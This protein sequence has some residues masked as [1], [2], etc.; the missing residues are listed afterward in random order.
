[1]S[2][3]GR[4]APSRP[5]T[6]NTPATLDAGLDAC[7]ERGFDAVGRLGDAGAGFITRGEGGLASRGGN[8]RPPIIRERLGRTELGGRGVDGGLPELD[9]V[10]GCASAQQD[11]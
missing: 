11:V 9:L 6:L 3:G 5:A 8:G 7:D 4:N 1:L 2:R 10:M